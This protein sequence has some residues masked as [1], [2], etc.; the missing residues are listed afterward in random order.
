MS[1][2]PTPPE[3]GPKIAGW[4]ERYVR[5]MDDA[6]KVPGTRVGVGVDPIVGMIIPGAGDALTGAGSIALLLLALKE[7]VPTVVIA[8]MVLNILVDTLLGFVP[9]GGDIFDLFFRS[10]RRNLALIEAHRGGKKP[11]A[12]DYVVV[13][14]GIFLAVLSVVLP[15]L[16]V[17]GLGAGALYAL[18]RLVS[19]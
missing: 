8:K 5:F 3:L 13:A 15:F 9:V 11:R 10:N 16:I 14:V 12:R 19:G 2:A 4:A 17:Y 18:W 7:G 6:V 1:A